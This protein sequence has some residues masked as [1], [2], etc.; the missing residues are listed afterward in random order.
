MSDEYSY[1]V[2]LKRGDGHDVQKCTVT[3]GTI[4][5]LDEKVDNLTEKMEEWAGEWRSIQPMD[6]RTLS[7][8]QDTLTEVSRS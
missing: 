1:T 8:D 7:E 2:K 6:R 3:A 4:D 5:E